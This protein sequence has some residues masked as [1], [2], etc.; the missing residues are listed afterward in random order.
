MKD[1][2]VHIT[3]WK[4]E[5]ARIARRQRRPPDE[6]GLNIND[7]NHL[8]YERWRR[9]PPAEILAWHRAV[10]DDVLT[11]LRRHPKVGSAAE[12]VTK[13]SPS[14]LM[15]TPPTTALRTSSAR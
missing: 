11:A 15:A 10:H 8:I 3:Y 9:R 7:L 1:A 6:R 14:T 5:V 12:S 4:A 13:S 2:L